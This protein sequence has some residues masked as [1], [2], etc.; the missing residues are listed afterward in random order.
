MVTDHQVRKL[1][2]EIQREKKMSVAA[3]KAGMDEK[4]AR[5][6]RDLEQ[7]PSQLKKQRS[8]RT[9]PDIFAE[10]W[11]NVEGFLQENPTVLATTLFD[12]LCRQYPDRF[13]EGHIRTLQRRIKIWKATKGQ[14]K[15]IM[16]PQ[17]H[18]PGDQGQSD[19]TDMS[20]L[21]I[22]IGGQEFRHLLYHFTLPYS[23]WES[24]KICF[25]ESFE[26]LSGGLQHALWNLGAVP[27]DHRT[28]CLSAAIKNQCD[29]ERFTARYE[30]LLGHYGMTAT[31]N[32]A[33]NANENGDIEQSHHRFK[34]AVAQELILR[35]SHDFGDRP[36]YEH[37]LEQI[38]KRRNGLRREKVIEELE[39]MRRLPERRLEDFTAERVRVTRN[40][41]IHVRHNT[42]SVDSRL[43]RE[44]I[45]VR[46]FSEH[47]EVW[48]AGQ[49]IHELPR[50]RG[51][52]NHFIN[53]RHI[54]NSLIRKPGAFANY[55]YKSDLFP[56]IVFRIAY[57]ELQAKTA[58]TADRQYLSILKL[59]ADN[60]EDK[61]ND[62]LHFLLLKGEGIS[63][64]RVKELLNNERPLPR[65]Q[66]TIEQVE[67]Q[68]YD[69]LLEVASWVR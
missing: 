16:F 27:K 7:L 21:G 20:E 5:K 41:T 43:M 25:S 23:N 32:T 49:R 64:V 59:A 53:Y 15:E 38:E 35:G 18:Y 13:S 46:I 3:A 31:H 50:L 57:D 65:L 48:Y 28:D 52:S 19:F 8:W 29:P 10:V 36:E 9:R 6:Y 58:A 26:A 34:L 2:K 60:G 37:F 66:V 69:G 47:L 39:V 67:I 17:V 44:W 24:V 4:T 11:P 1:M 42:Y 40:S 33:G 12:Y 14:P 51:E 45:D 61:I 56:R 63:L 62:I 22:T 68:Q 30:A 55:K 54:I